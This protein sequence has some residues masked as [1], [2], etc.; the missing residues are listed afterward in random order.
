V[1][2]LATVFG[3][4]GGTSSYE[5]V[6][7]TDLIVLW[8][9]NARETH[10]IFFHHVLRGIRGGARL[11]VVDPRRT[12]SAQWADVWMG[13]DVGSDIALSNTMAREIIRAGLHN[14]AFIEN[15]TLG[16]DEYAASVED[17]TLDRGAEVTGIPGEVIRDFAHA[18]AN[19]DRAILCWTLGIT[20]HHNA[21]DNVLA[22]INL[23]LLC[24]HVGRYGSGLNPLRGQNNVQGGGDMGAIP[25]KLPGFRDIEK[26]ADARAMFA[27]AW[28]CT[29]PPTY[30]M[31]LT[32]MF[33]AMERGELTAV[34]VIGENP[35]HSEAD[36]ARAKRLLAGLDTLIVQD[37]FLT[38]TAEMADVVF[39]AASS[40]A[41]SEGTVTNSERRVQLMRKALEPPGNARDD[42][43]IIG[44]LAARLGR[45]WGDPTP[46][47]M[48]DE[49]R[50]LSPMHAGM[51]YERLGANAQG[52][53]QWPCWDEG[54]PGT[55]FLHARL[56]DPDPEKRLAA[57]PFSVVPFE[58]PVDELSD[59]FPIRLT[60]GRRLDSYN[61][62]VQSG[63]YRSPMRTREAICLSPEDAERHGVVE[64]ERVRVSSRRGTV[65]APIRIDTSLRPGLAFMTLHFPEQVE[66]NALTIDATDPKSG[67][68]EFKASAVR[69]DRIET[70]DAAA[71]PGGSE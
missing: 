21:V 60:T 13:L 47:S 26:D 27:A 63:R 20:E 43:W 70:T 62:G 41:E 58:P 71:I 48:W 16:F 50:S 15:G 46:R 67:T 6:E 69:I 28:D 14:T 40:W 51:T 68:A 54:H 9:S 29:I 53:I 8:G 45:D 17:W 25:N 59:E 36:A 22:L 2:G 49:L 55:Q 37:I 34:Y 35:A 31:H 19:A 61:T 12:S 64:G 7:N 65:E 33:E 5:E 32:A 10:P 56:W 52:G 30:G 44:Q 11:Y 24:G 57:A 42:I 23:G 38:A 39:P 3:A 1:V 18:Y 66:T 4:G